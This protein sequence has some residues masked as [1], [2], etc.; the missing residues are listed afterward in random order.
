MLS[1]CGSSYP[2]FD[3][4]VSP[5][6]ALV[7][8]YGYYPSVEVDV[9]GLSESDAVKFSSYPVDKYFEDD[10]GLRAYLEP[11]TMHFSQEDLK[12]KVLEPDNEA[13][14]RIM[15]KKPVYLV[16]IANLPYADKENKTLDPRKYILKIEDGFFSS[17]SDLYIKIGATGLI[18]TTK[19]EALRDT[20]ASLESKN[21]PVNVSLKC[22]GKKDSKD[23]S[24]TTM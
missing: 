19:K 18:K 11:Y 6:T 23:L 1:G 24:C 5:S 9:A 2:E 10:S 13:F 16:L 8:K 12:T 15:E 17:Q 22:T 7:K 20:P 4:Q 3:I 14:E 21:E